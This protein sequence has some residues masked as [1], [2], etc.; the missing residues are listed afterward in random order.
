MLE[1]SVTF[2]WMAVLC[3]A[4]S[5]AGPPASDELLVRAGAVGV[6]EPGN[7]TGTGGSGTPSGAASSAGT[8]R[9]A[10]N[11]VIG[12]IDSAT[13]GNEADGTESSSSPGGDAD[14]GSGDGDGGGASMEWLPSWATTIQRTEPN[15]LPPALAQNTLRQFVWPT[16]SGQ[17]IRIQL[18]NE[19]GTTPVDIQKVHIA[20]ALTQADPANSG[21][22]IDPA[23]DAAF[24]FNGQA[25]VT[26]PAGQ[27]VWSDALDFPLQ[28]IRLTAVSMQ[29]GGAVPVEITGHPGSRTTSYVVNGDAVAQPGLAGAQTRDRWYFINAIEVMAPSDAYAIALLGDSITDGYGVLNR[30]ARWG[31]FM[32]L[33]IQSDGRIADNRSV[34]NFGMG[35]NNLTSSNTNQDAGVI[36]FERDVLTRDKIKWLI[37]FEGINDIIGGVQ[38][39]VIIDAYSQI[40][41]KAREKGILVYGSPIT[42]N[43]PNAVR[44]AVND[45]V[46]TSGAFDQVI[47]FDATIRDP[48]NVDSILPMYNND[49]LHPSLAGYEAMG[50]SVD[51]SLFYEPMSR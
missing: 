44:T 45:W 11:A 14:S 20:M 31:D 12:G 4:C 5:E 27:T 15:N 39:Q 10:S 34:L 37:V 26:I 41:Q 30:F 32:T 8:D 1:Q 42:P 22:Q 6:A 46:R 33:A 50:N 18:S 2:G 28:E 38:A 9:E 36:R 25:N 16:V 13:D 48:S 29:F 23:T 17:Q 49:G 40:I 19:K 3:L 51:L 7:S 24:T 43:G 35:A 47:D 21:G